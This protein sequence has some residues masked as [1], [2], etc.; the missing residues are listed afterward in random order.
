VFRF[1]T[2]DLSALPPELE[3][4]L[5]SQAYRNVEVGACATSEAAGFS[6]YRIAVIFF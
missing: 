3:K 4:K 2:G 6:R 1:E 5:H